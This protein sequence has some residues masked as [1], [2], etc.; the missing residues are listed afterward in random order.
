MSKDREAGRTKDEA[1]R[2]IV[3]MIDASMEL[4][5]RIGNHPLRNGC[6]CIAC[7]N[8]RKRLIFET[9]EEWRYRL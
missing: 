2:A 6:N 5:E 7:I 1:W 3:E 4:A 8:K 9:T